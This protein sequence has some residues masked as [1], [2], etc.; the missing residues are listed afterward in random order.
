MPQVLLAVM[1]IAGLPSMIAEYSNNSFFR[2]TINVKLVGLLVLFLFFILHGAKDFLLVLTILPG[3][4]ALSGA[5]FFEKVYRK[6]YGD[7]YQKM[8]MSDIFLVGVIHGLIIILATTIPAVSG[9]LEAYFYYSEKAIDFGYKKQ[10]GILFEGFSI[11]SVTQAMTFICGLSILFD[12]DKKSG[13]SKLI[14][15]V[16]IFIIFF[17]ILLC[18][19]L[20]LLVFIVAM[21]FFTW[22]IFRA[23]IRIIPRKTKLF[24][25]YI[26]L[27]IICGGVYLY[28]FSQDFQH[29]SDSLSY[30]FELFYSYRDNGSFETR[31]TNLLFD[32]MYF[33]PDTIFE[34][35]IGTGN[36]GRSNDY[37]S[38]DVGY[39]LIIFGAGLFG[40]FSVFFFYVYLGYRSLKITK[41]NPM[42]SI[43]LFLFC[44]MIIMVNFKDIILDHMLGLSQ[45]FS[46]CYVMLIKLYSSYRKQNNLIV[47]YPAN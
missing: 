18:A 26:I 12:K 35:I 38:S 9:F 41:L 39:I 27:I 25:A 24:L 46:V 23:D 4:G 43:A 34:T 1:G 14:M 19:R 5:F 33:L 10:S 20:G 17:S 32:E 3:F 42:V 16:G 2:S 7:G 47:S 21:A 13:I 8:I 30:T 6:S 45:I 29:L 11:L 40:V 44:V 28:F 31:T 15:F 22:K 36:F 37:I